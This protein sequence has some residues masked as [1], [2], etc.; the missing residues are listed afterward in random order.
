[1]FQR[2]GLAF[3]KRYKHLSEVLPSEFLQDLDY[4]YLAHSDG[5]ITL[6]TLAEETLRTFE[7]QGKYLQALNEQAGGGFEPTWY[8]R[9]LAQ[10]RERLQ[11]FLA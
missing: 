2:I 8:W 1:M 4:T 7:M 10:V 3:A 5:A 11:L 9:L 6:A